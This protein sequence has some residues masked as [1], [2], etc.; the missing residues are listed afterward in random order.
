MLFLMRREAKRDEENKRQSKSFPT[1]LHTYR[2]REAYFYSYF[3][4]K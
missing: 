2:H 1:Q 3:I 4:H